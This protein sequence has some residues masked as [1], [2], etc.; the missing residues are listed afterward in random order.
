MRRYYLSLIFILTMVLLMD[1]F[2]WAGNPAK[3]SV[4]L[5]SGPQTWSSYAVMVATSDVINRHSNLD[6]TV[7]SYDGA[8]AIIQGLVTKRT[9]LSGGPKDGS[10]AMAYNATEDFSGKPPALN[11]R[12]VIQAMTF[13]ET[14][15]TPSRTGVKSITDLKGKRIPWFTAESNAL[16][17][18]LLKAN[19][20]NPDKDIIKVPMPSSATVAQEMRMGRID[21][22]EGNPVAPYMIELSQAVGPITI[23]PLEPEKL[24]WLKQHY[25]KV[26]TGVFLR[27]IGPGWAAHINTPK[28]IPVPVTTIPVVS[29]EDVS[30]EIVY[31]YTK[32]WLN[33]LTEIRPLHKYLEDLGPDVI[34]LPS[35]MPYHEGAIRGLKESK[36]WSEQMDRV[37]QR[38]LGKQ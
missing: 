34:S 10:W 17:E 19:G 9:S 30:K 13:I 21:A 3:T 24:D 11:L 31:E 7:R 6:I 18:G 29:R 8:L 14:L 35:S 22:A 36:L 37:H 26:F 4:L 23:L 32:T 1:R 15:F 33:H 5:G 38:M 16:T 2:S 12:T 27:N 20:L 25:P 28:V